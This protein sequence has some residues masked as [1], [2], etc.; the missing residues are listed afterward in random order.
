MG[1]AVVMARSDNGNQ[2][3]GKTLYC[4]AHQFS[5][6]LRLDFLSSQCSNNHSLAQGASDAQS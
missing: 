6:R 5:R 2:C 4:S 1:H 3:K